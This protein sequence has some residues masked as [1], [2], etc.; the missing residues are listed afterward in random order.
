MEQQA[1]TAEVL[2]IISSSPG[3]L[4]P[5]FKTMLANA[6]RLC[7][8]SYGAMWLR[9]GDSFRN[10]AFYGA[11]QAA[12]VEQWKSAT[13]GYTAPIGRIAESKKPLQ[14]ADLRKDQTYLDG[15]PF[16]GDGCRPRCSSSC[17]PRNLG[18][19]PYAQGGRVRRG[20]HHLS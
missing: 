3:E 13:M 14:V 8:A 6:T 15:H 17:A 11:L 4:D 5:V 20:H 18:P 7:E 10:A 1:A 9:E 19:R 12:Y 2:R 16:D